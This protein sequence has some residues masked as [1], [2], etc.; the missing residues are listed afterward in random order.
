MTKILCSTQKGQGLLSSFKIT[1]HAAAKIDTSSS[2]HFEQGFVFFLPKLPVV[3]NDT[4]D[5][6]CQF[7]FLRYD[8]SSSS[9]QRDPRI[10]FPHTSRPHRAWAWQRHFTLQLA[11]QRSVWASTTFSRQISTRVEYDRGSSSFLELFSFS[12]SNLNLFLRRSTRKT[13]VFFGYVS[14]VADSAPS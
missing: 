10:R 12:R 9:P 2:S 8:A 11:S 5:K 6:A 14:R 4:I 1:P 13:Q 3:R 7:S